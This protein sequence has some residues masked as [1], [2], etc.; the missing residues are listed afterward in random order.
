MLCDSRNL[1]C[2]SCPFVLAPHGLPLGAI[3]WMFVDRISTHSM[4]CHNVALYRSHA[5]NA[6]NSLHFSCILL[7]VKSYLPPLSL[8]VYYTLLQCFIFNHIQVLLSTHQQSSSIP[9]ICFVILV[10]ALLQCSLAT[11]RALHVNNAHTTLKCFIDPIGHKFIH[12]IHLS[13]SLVVG[14][15]VYDVAIKLY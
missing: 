13:I 11:L 7:Y 4:T 3:Q 2:F 15:L 1:Y 5:S 14:L 12:D 8:H 9:T 6:A 10:C